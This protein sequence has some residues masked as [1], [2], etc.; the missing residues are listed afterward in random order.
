[1]KVNNGAVI[2]YNYEPCVSVVNK[3][4]IQSKTPS[5]VTL[6]RDSIKGKI[7]LEYYYIYILR[8]EMGRKEILKTRIYNLFKPQNV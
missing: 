4:N 1:V 3:S 6:T 5:I 8:Y 2:K 7:T